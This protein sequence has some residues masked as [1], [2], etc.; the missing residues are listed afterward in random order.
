[1]STSGSSMTLG[2]C[3]R[4]RVTMRGSH[5]IAISSVTPKRIRRTGGAAPSRREWMRF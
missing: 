5:V 4:S 3:S 1:M 2:N